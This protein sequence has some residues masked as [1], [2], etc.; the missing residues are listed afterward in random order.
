M[1]LGVGPTYNA[2]FDNRIKITDAS[3]SDGY[4]VNSPAGEY[5]ILFANQITTNTMTN[6]HATIRTL[7]IALLSSWYRCS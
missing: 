2:P 1:K 6:Q 4:F 7:R 5:G 3:G